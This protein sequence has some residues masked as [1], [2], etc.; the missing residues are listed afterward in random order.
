MHP[1]LRLHLHWKPLG[2]VPNRERICPA[3]V[4]GFDPVSKVVRA[5]KGVLATTECT[6]TLRS[7]GYMGE[8]GVER[9]ALDDVVEKDNYGSCS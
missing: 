5:E 4:E 1:G 2:G 3:Q 6:I 8:G 7:E 9:F